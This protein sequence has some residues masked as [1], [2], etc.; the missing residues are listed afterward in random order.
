MSEELV[1]AFTD[2]MKLQNYSKFVCENKNRTRE[3]GKRI[4]MRKISLFGFEVF[5]T[6]IMKTRLGVFWDRTAC[7]L[8]KSA[9]VSVEHTT[10]IPRV[11]KSKQEA[12]KTQAEFL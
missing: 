2:A 10:P 5:A 6:L 9:D 4:K 7:N 1:T 8:V 3:A 11:N 12:S